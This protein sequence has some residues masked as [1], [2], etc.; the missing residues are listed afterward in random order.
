MRSVLK[1]AAATLNAATG[2]VGRLKQ[3]RHGKLSPVCAYTL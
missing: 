1:V 2:D 3:Q